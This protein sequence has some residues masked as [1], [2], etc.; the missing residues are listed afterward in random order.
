MSRLGRL[1][2]V[3]TAVIGLLALI[4]GFRLK[5]TDSALIMRLLRPFSTTVMTKELPNNTSARRAFTPSHSIPVA[6]S[7]ASVSV[8]MESG[9]RTIADGSAESNSA[10]F[11]D[12]KSH[13][14]ATN[15]P[16]EPPTLPAP[17]S[18]CDA[19]K[20]DMSSGRGTIKMDHLGPMV[21]NKDGT[22]SSISNW[23]KMTD[24]EKKNTLKV[25]GK[26]NQARRDALKMRE[27]EV[28]DK[29]E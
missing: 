20:L 5:G 24:L 17:H 2:L 25:L 4:S 11:H 3:V 22:L 8:I 28:Q 7:T 9:T 14:D 16:S 6:S 10:D 13:N 15:I 29:T 12:T 21:V 1:A 26:R 23:D 27:G 18:E 19:Q